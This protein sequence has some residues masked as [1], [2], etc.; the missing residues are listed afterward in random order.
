MPSSQDSPECL[1]LKSPWIRS[2]YFPLLPYSL[3]HGI[4]R[5]GGVGWGGYFTDW[6]HS[7]S[8][9]SLFQDNAFSNLFH[10]LSERCK[11]VFYIFVTRYLI[12]R[13]SNL[14]TA[15]GDY[16]KEE[17]ARVHW[18]TMF[19]FIFNRSHNL[20]LTLTGLLLLSEPDHRRDSGHESFALCYVPSIHPSSLPFMNALLHSLLERMQSDWVTRRFSWGDLRWWATIF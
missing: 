14:P 6:L 1:E 20:S 10:F 9:I 12:L 16:G 3:S 2:V 18:D 4:N 7:S 8:L 15:I 17:N 13:R 19:L 11:N 5:V